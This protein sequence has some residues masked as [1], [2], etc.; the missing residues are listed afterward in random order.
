MWS[1]RACSGHRKSRSRGKD[2]DA[3][4]DRLHPTENSVATCE[5]IRDSEDIVFPIP[6]HARQYSLGNV[7]PQRLW[8]DT[9]RCH[10]LASLRAHQRP[11]NC[12]QY[13]GD[14]I[15]SASQ[16]HTLKVRGSSHCFIE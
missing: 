6:G 9:I 8:E 5:S 10:S 1:D 12:L 15:V 2:S 14:R 11:I 7:R 16:D 13:E 4:R 3:A